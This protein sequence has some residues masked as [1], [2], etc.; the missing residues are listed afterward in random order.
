MEGKVDRDVPGN[1]KAMSLSECL[2]DFRQ[3]VSLSC[4]GPSI[5][6]ALHSVFPR[7]EDHNSASRVPS[8]RRG[9]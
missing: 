4:P 7:T 8:L 6:A 5:Q 2:T 3:I 1:A 9:F